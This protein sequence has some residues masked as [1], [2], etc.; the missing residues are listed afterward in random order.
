M[1]RKDVSRAGLVQ[2]ALA[3][4]I[5]NR[6]GAQALDLRRM[7]SSVARAIAAPYRTL[8]LAPVRPVR[9]RALMTAAARRAEFVLKTTLA[10]CPATM[11]ARRM[12]FV[13]S[14]ADAT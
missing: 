1:S 11:L 14:G 5:T 7:P 8:L 3:G 13:A 12:Q 4:L 10:D 2:A 9:Y 6:E